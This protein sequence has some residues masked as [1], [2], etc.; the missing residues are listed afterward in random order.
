M[1]EPL[2][3]A[4]M[5]LINLIFGAYIFLVLIRVVLQW[6]GSNFYNP[7]SQLIIRATQMPLSHLQ[8]VIP[9]YAGIDI[10]GIS[11]LLILT[12][13]KLL[14]L[15]ALSA[16]VM[17]HFGGLLIWA[18]ADLFAQG[19]N[20]FF[21]ATVLSA[22]MSWFNP[23]AY[24]P[25]LEMVYSLTEPLLRPVRRWLPPLGGFDLTPVVVLAGLQMATIL[26]AEPLIV[27][28]KRLAL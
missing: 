19:I 17:P 25:I 28:G 12:M 22:I 10:A 1:L 15:I 7:I 4:G 8:R 23:A 6:M 3:Q 27:I 16:M 13:L 20:I 9:S 24:S 14:L 18:F 26:L 11:W 2:N 5:F 21:Y